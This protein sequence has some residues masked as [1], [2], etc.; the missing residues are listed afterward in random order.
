M[1]L[2]GKI[3][4]ITGAAGGI[5]QAIAVEFAQGGA[6]VVVSDVRAASDRVEVLAKR[7]SGV[8]LIAD[9]A[10]ESDI[11]SLVNKTESEVGPIDAFVSNAGV[12]FPGTIDAPDHQWDTSWRVHVMSHLYAARAVLPGM[13]ARGSGYLVNTASAA[14]LLAAIESTS[15]GVTKHAAVALAEHLA[16]EYGER[17]I[18]VSVLCPQAVDTEMARTGAPTTSRL[19][20]VMSPADVAIALVAGM[21]EERFLIL[22]HEKVH[23]YVQRKATDIDRWLAGMR[24]LRNSRSS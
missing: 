24:R 16:I 10:N 17:G 3:C 12:L 6:R 9:V 19:D 22:P 1:D 5:G 7:V 4:V 2:D 18:R 8:A 20:G 13:V 14:G 23:E 11:R 15:Y 21:R